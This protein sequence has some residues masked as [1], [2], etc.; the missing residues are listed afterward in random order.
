MKILPTRVKKTEQK[1]NHMNILPTR[2]KK[3]E[4]KQPHEDLAN[5]GSPVAAQAL[6][7]PT[8]VQFSSEIQL[9]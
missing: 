1:N 7:R 2:V 3:T 8:Y 9:M 6:T 5:L 4:K